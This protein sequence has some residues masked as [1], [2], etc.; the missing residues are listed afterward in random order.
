MVDS[1]LNR[2][3]VTAEELDRALVGPGS[4]EARSTLGRCSGRSRSATETR[5][6]LVLRGAGFTVRAGVVI[7][8]VGEVDLLVE[9]C[10]VV[11]CDGF[12]YH[13]GRREYREDRR[14]DRE[15]VALGYVVLRFTWEDI[16]GDCGRLVDAVARALAQV[17][18]ARRA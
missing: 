8:G 13:S 9:D 16:T 14:R 6:R 15:L 12:S 5:A 11:E 1:A 17:R 2:R 3:L 7:D 10:V 18:N 4:V